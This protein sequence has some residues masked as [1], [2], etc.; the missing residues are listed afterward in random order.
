MGIQVEYEDQ[1]N[2]EKQSE[3]EILYDVND[4]AA[5][6]FSN[7]LLNENEGEIGR[8]YFHQRKIKIRQ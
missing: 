7:I 3:Q 8:K 6:Y 2:P 4:F 1:Q 5:K